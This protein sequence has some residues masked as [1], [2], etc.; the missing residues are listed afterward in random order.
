MALGFGPAVH[1]VV[2]GCSHGFQVLGVVALKPENELRRHAAGQVGVFAV[3]FHAASPARVAKE[4]DVG[5]PEGEALI[6]IALAAADELMMLGARFIGD[7]G[8]N[9]EEQVRIPGGSQ[10]DGFRE[11]GGAAGARHAVQAFAPPVVLRNA[12]AIDGRGIVHELRDLLLERQPPEQIVDAFFERSAGVLVSRWL[13]EQ[14][15]EPSGRGKTFDKAEC[16]HDSNLEDVRK[17][18][19]Y[20]ISQFASG[21]PAVGRIR[22][23]ARHKS[24]HTFQHW[25]RAKPRRGERS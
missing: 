11:H 20:N 15:C 4:I 23:R 14:G 16:G 2:L 18:L 19:P 10:A 8:G 17:L 1:G 21:A 7:G 5:A 3:S 6:D 24:G 13:R 9:A 12:Q 22:G 25:V